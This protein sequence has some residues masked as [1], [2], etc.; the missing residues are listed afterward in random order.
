MF[1]NAVILFGF[2]WMRATWSVVFCLCLACMAG[3]SSA[4]VT[5]HC[6]QA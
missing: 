4:P 1:C 5:G 6:V 2:P 3:R